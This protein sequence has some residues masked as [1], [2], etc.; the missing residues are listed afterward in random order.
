MLQEQQSLTSVRK[1]DSAQRKPIAAEVEAGSVSER[2]E[3][4]VSPAFGGHGG[5][6]FRYSFGNSV[7]KITTMIDTQTKFLRQLIYEFDDGTII[8]SGGFNAEGTLKKSDSII[9]RNDVISELYLKVEGDGA[10]A[11]DKDLIGVTDIY[12]RTLR[13][14]T[15]HGVGGKTPN[16][17]SWHLLVDDQGRPVKNFYISGIFGKDQD[18]VDRL[19]FIYVNDVLSSRVIESFD[20]SNLHLVGSPEPLNLSTVSLRNTSD[21]DQSATVSFSES[22]SSGMTWSSSASLTLGITTT[23]TTGI[24]FVGD[25]GVEIGTETTISNTWGEETSLNQEFAYNAEVN[26]P[27]KSKIIADAV[28]SKQKLSGTFSA[29]MIEN[30]Q[31]GGAIEKNISGDVSGVSAYNVTVNYKSEKL[32]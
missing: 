31:Y 5:N 1:P 9:L 30:W 16:N 25:A 7:T 19:G 6:P 3:E 18:Y 15:L 32:K 24:P 14:E 26:V 22:I 2:P 23:L 10:F 28:V 29:K 17:K 13:G 11:G 27:A 12:I 21:T 20:Y 8:Y 4:I